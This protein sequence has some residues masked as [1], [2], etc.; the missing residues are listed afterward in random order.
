MSES[1]LAKLDEQ[2]KKAK[3]AC[4]KSYEAQQAALMATEVV[5]W[6]ERRSKLI[7]ESERIAAWANL[8]AV[9][10][11]AQKVAQKNA[12]ETTALAVMI[13]WAKS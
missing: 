5:A 1:E 11:I 9:S 10:K 13:M 12:E 2:I 4:F 6:S 3:D 7:P 8:G